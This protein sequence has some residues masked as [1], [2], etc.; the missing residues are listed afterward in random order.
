MP[1]YSLEP[2]NFSDYRDFLRTRFEA[3]RVKNKTFSLN[4]CALKSKLSKSL[5][6]FIFKKKRHVGIDR[7]PDLAKALKLTAEEEYFIYLLICRNTSRSSVIQ[8]YFEKILDRVRHE[9]VVTSESAPIPVATN[10][11]KLYLNQ[12]LMILHGMGQLKGFQEDP[13]WIQK[14]LKIPDIK[15]E[16]IIAGLKELEKSGYLF[17][18]QQGNLKAKS[19]TF[20]RPD[21]FDPTGLQVFTKAAESMAYLMKQ[22]QIYKPSVY[23]SMTLPMDEEQLALAEKLMI[24]V[25]HQLLKMSKASSEPTALVQVANFLLTVVR[26]KAGPVEC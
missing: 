6:Q 8:N 10:D 26:H 15:S 14:N 13:E 1:I 16:D 25:H 17:R 18:D 3:L 5:L 7:M 23:M 21:P 20:W 9:Y 11:K 24:E 4:A 19:D 12:L 2:A 22:P